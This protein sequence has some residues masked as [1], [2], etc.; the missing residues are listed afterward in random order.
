MLID[1]QVPSEFGGNV[2]MILDFRNSSGGGERG[3]GLRT[4]VLQ[5]DFAL[6]EHTCANTN[7]S[8]LATGHYVV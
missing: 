3:G 7:H 4:T 8:F 6:S 2:Q 1:M 5:C